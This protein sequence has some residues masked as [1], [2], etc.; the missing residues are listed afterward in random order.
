[1]VK[2]GF[3]KIIQMFAKKLVKEVKGWVRIAF[4]EPFNKVVS[5]KQLELMVGIKSS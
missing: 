3:E 4:P 2:N 5:Q 1:V